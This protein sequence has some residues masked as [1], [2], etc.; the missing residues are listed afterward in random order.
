MLPDRYQKALRSL[1]AKKDITVL[2]ADKGGAVGVLLTTKYYAL[3]LDV[4]KDTT[5]F[6]PVQEGDKT[7]RNVA[8]MQAEHNRRIK[9]IGERV[10]DKNLQTTVN[11]LVSPINPK[12][13]T[14][15][16]YPK[17][18][19]D[20]VKVRPVISNINAPHSCSSRWL[21]NNFKVM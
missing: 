6:K 20:P 5:T 21:L 12:M 9:A 14:M 10:S 13:P 18:H 15:T 1:I 7:G 16:G 4:L 11:R 3:G 2:S 17:F 8:D 19:K